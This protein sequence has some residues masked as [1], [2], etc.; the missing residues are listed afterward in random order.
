MLVSHQTL[1]ARRDYYFSTTMTFD[2]KDKFSGCLVSGL[3]E[4]EHD[5]VVCLNI[6]KAKCT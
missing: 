4:G 2:L 6:T 1:G 3:S 5:G